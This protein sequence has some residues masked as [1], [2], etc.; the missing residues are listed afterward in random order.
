MIFTKRSDYGLRAALE[1]AAGYGD[2]TMSAH[3]IATEGGL[4]EPFVR[5]LLQE[6]A[7]A[8]LATSSRGRH[9]GYELTKPPSAM[10]AYSNNTAPTINRV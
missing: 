10:I 4:P 7:R 6:L 9:G 8:G 2:G 1:L 3:R 5:K